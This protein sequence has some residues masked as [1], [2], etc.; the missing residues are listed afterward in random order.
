MPSQEEKMLGDF[1]AAPAALRDFMTLRQFTDIFPRA[2]R[3]SS[4]VQDLYCELHRLR[5]KDVEAVRRDIVMEV[6]RSKPLKRDYATE[7]R[8]ADIATVAGLD[9]VARQLEGELDG[10]VQKNPHSLQSLCTSVEQACHS[11]EAQ[12]AEMEEES[13]TALRD[14]QDAVGA[15]SDLRQ[16]RFAQSTGGEELG[17]EVLATLRRLDAICLQP[18]G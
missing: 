7:K 15:L 9:L 1:L 2:H 4:A 3:S 12:I 14:V 16:G 10:Q 11:L 5:E 17:E 18:V 6:K 8:L 13:R